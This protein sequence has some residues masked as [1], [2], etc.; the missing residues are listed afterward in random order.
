MEEKPSTTSSTLLSGFAT[1]ILSTLLYALAAWYVARTLNDNDV[2]SWKLS[3]TA[4]SSMAFTLQ[5]VRVWDRA[6]M[7]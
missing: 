3:W 6:F 5:F 2:I 1:F 7:R 4:A